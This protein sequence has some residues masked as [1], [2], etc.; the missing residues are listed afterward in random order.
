MSLAGFSVATLFFKTY[1]DFPLPNRPNPASS[2]WHPRLHFAYPSHTLCVFPPL[3]L[4]F[5]QAGLYTVFCDASTCPQQPHHHHQY[6]RAHGWVHLSVCKH[7]YM[8]ILS[9]WPQPVYSKWKPLFVL[10]Y[11]SK[12]LVFKNKMSSTSCTKIL[13]N[14]S[15]SV[16][17]RQPE[18]VSPRMVVM[19]INPS[20]SPQNLSTVTTGSKAQ[21]S[22][23]S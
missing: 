11:Q 3:N 19:N 22:A 6:V 12:Y 13:L 10:L 23:F 4:P 15:L 7:T 18:S 20:F 1:G 16:V 9:L 21:E 5:S 17:L 14:A 2:P 8:P